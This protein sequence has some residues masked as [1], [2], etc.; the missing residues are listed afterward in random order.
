MKYKNLFDGRKV[1]TFGYGLYK[2]EESNKGDQEMFN[3]IV[4]GLNRGINVIDT[5]QRYRNGRSERLLKR[6]LYKFKKRKNL[7]I[8][9][10][11]GLIP[12]YIKKKKILDKLKIK[13]SNCLLEYDYCID[14]R[15]IDWSLDNS[16]KLMNTKY[17]DF[18]LLHNPELSLMM[19]NGQKKIIEALKML[20]VKRKEK[21][22]LYYG[23]A[24]WNGFRRLNGNNYQLNIKKILKDLEREIG[25]DHGFRCIEAPI[26]LGMP[27]ILNYKVDKNFNLTNFLKKNKINF[28]SS[29][30][31][32]EGNL[33]NL[34]VLNK[35][36]NS[37]SIN[38]DMTNETKKAKVS[39][40]LSENSL[41]R[42]FI[43]LENFRK[44]KIFIK[45]KKLKLSKLKSIY[46]TGI[47]FVKTL[48]FVTSSL[49]G[50]DKKKF[51]I[52]NL[53][54]FAYNLKQKDINYINSL[55][56]KIKINL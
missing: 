55:W 13:K 5:A 1:S 29:A 40:P 2:G 25:K 8:I 16:L 39:F 27:D 45:D 15:Y 47:S 33:E 12:N 17:I 46:G 37:I 54:E 24:T 10:K 11:V 43:L 14:P 51:V 19:E 50:M 44:S 32:Y 52:F 3:S 42:L 9:S 18:Y 49:V 30:S 22:I 41:R 23:I 20:E 4:Y 21:K 34:A 48:Q 53:K 7:I 26:S 38:K 6:I 36:F 28:F 31:L 56:K 35:I